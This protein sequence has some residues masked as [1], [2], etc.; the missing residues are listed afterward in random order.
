M[1]NYK[2]AQKV[3]PMMIDNEFGR[4]VNISSLWSFLTVPGRAA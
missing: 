4:I 3:L 1:A 2:L